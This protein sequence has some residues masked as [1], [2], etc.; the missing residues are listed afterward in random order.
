V[1]LIGRTYAAAIERRRVRAGENDA[2]YVAAVAPATIGSEIDKWLQSTAAYSTPTAQSLPAIL[3][4]HARVT[5]LFSRISGLEKRSLAS[6]YLH[7]H[8]PHL[9]YIYDSRAVEALRKLSSVVGSPARGVSPSDSDSE[10]RKLAVK[11]LRLQQYIEEHYGV[12]LTPREIDNLLLEVQR[13]DGAAS[14]VS[15]DAATARAGSPR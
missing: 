6:K 13:E 3:S 8:Q 14:S 15:S 10:Y 9:F 12:L 5:S 11:C 7:F 2:F 4:T 1:W